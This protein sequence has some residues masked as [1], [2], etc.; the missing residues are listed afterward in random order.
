MT[1][2]ALSGTDEKARTCPG[3]QS[4]PFDMVR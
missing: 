4:Q 1:A 3:T 2:L